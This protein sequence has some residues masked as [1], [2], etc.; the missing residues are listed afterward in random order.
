MSQQRDQPLPL[1]WLLCVQC[2]VRPWNLPV[3]CDCIV[4]KDSVRHGQC[5]TPSMRLLGLTLHIGEH[6]ICYCT[7]S[8]LTQA[9]AL[10]WGPSLRSAWAMTASGLS[11]IFTGS[12]INTPPFYFSWEE[13]PKYMTGPK[14]RAVGFGATAT[15]TL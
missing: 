9:W 13:I 4:S 1:R 3:V 11:N 5:M 10:K 2:L 6:P 7:P 14:P 12:L 8:S 15:R